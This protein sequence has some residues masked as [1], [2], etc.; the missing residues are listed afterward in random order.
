LMYIEHR[1][2]RVTTQC[3]AF[4]GASANPA[5]SPPFLT[6]PDAFVIPEQSQDLER[7][8]IIILVRNSGI[9]GYKYPMESRHPTR[10]IYGTHL[11]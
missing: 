8:G 3:A 9:A 5:S 1:S 4:H 6:L 2:D 10:I 7:F 11:P